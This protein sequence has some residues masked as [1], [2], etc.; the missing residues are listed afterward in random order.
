MKISKISLYPLK[1]PLVSHFETSFGRIHA[2]ECVL[3]QMEADGLVGWG[4]CV[5]DRDPVGL[6]SGDPHPGDPEGEPG[7]RDPVRVGARGEPD[8]PPDAG[9]ARVP[10][11][12]PEPPA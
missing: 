11:F 3:V 4:E 6:E 2:R 9:V 5:A 12:R 7:G 8:P 1:M 10:P